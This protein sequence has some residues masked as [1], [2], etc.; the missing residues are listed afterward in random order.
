MPRRPSKQILCAFRQ[1][2][3]YAAVG[4]V[5]TAIGVAV[6]YGLMGLGVAP[7]PAN[8]GGY[9]VGLVI[10]FVLNSRITFQVGTSRRN[11]VRFLVVAAIAYVGNLLVVIGVLKLT[12]AAHVAQAMGIPVYLAVGYLANK[13][14]A[15]HQ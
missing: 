12:D 6:I 10:S 13:Y 2:L 15:L 4:A 3:T 14:W 5:N 9:V 11:L 8:V 1:P 7:I